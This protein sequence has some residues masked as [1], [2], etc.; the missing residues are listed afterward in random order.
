MFSC[1]AG[2]LGFLALGALAERSL[3]QKQKSLEL[4]GGIE[5]ELGLRLSLLDEEQAAGLLSG[6]RGMRNL[7]EIAAYEARAQD[8]MA[9]FQ[10]GK[11]PEAELVQA[12]REDANR[13]DD[14]FS[15]WYLI[16]G[17]LSAVVISCGLTV[18]CRGSAKGNADADS[19]SRWEVFSAMRSW[20]LMQLIFVDALVFTY[21]DPPDDMVP[22]FSSWK[23][24][25]QEIVN[26]HAVV[27]AIV[28]LDAVSVTSSLAL[29]VIEALKDANG[30]YSDYL[31]EN[32]SDSDKE[33]L[34]KH[35]RSVTWTIA[36]KE[37]EDDGIKGADLPMGFFNFVTAIVNM[38][39]VYG[40]IIPPTIIRGVG[41]FRKI[42]AAMKKTSKKVSGKR[43]SHIENKADAVQQLL[44]SINHEPDQSITVW[45]LLIVCALVA[46]L[47]LALACDSN[48]DDVDD[49]LV[50]LFANNTTA[51]STGSNTTA[52]GAYQYPDFNDWS[53]CAVAVTNTT[54]L[55]SLLMLVDF[56]KVVVQ[57]T[58]YGE[59]IKKDEKVV[60]L[61]GDSAD[62]QSQ[63]T[64]WNRIKL[65]FLI[66]FVF[67]ENYVFAVYDLFT[68]LVSLVGCFGINVP[69]SAISLA[70]PAIDESQQ[71]ILWAS[72]KLDKTCHR[73]IEEELKKSD[74]YDGEVDDGDQNERRSRSDQNE[75]RSSGCC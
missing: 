32:L 63:N 60:E 23:T 5:E 59:T 43:N 11:L 20:I 9:S 15:T 19:D 2:W 4:S 28:L 37:L 36:M 41:V 25:D 31:E 47:V 57:C 27:S 7:L 52:S 49:E 46:N 73:I 58:F 51:G 29:Q 6:E 18:L 70:K 48:V 26:F 54:L 17:I 56:F 38:L 65:G 10:A 24:Q 12:V 75:R 42:M 45:F 50:Q 53:S 40:P 71:N 72:D 3:L 64:W 69:A 39:L 34:Q 62:S 66:D 55:V 13:A 16:G 35:W 21:L 67:S 30:V 44:A 74:Y 14:V 61:L 1:C 68:T 22:D 8:E 33:L